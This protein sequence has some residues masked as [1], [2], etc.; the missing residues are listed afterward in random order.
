MVK[1]DL[2]HNFHL[3]LDS[4]EAVYRLANQLADDVV[5]S[6]YGIMPLQKLRIGSCITHKLLVHAPPPAQRVLRR[7]A[8]KVFGTQRRSLHI[9]VLCVETPHA[10]DRSGMCQKDGILGLSLPPQQ[11]SPSSSLTHST[12]R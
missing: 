12:A 4:I 11:L 1:Y 2:V 3:Q 6:E 9:N 5:P 10:P 7:G 8:G